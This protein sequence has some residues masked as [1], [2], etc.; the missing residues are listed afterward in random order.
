MNLMQPEVVRPRLAGR[1]GRSRVCASH[2]GV[3]HTRGGGGLR[4]GDD[5][6]L[7]LP[8]RTEGEDGEPLA[9]RSAS[10]Q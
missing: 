7:F 8:T 4:V 9:P 1:A 3:N 5:D 10:S 6:R 2:P